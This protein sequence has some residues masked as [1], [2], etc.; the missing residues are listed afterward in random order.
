[1][2]A[3]KGKF[4]L[5]SSACICGFILFVSVIGTARAQTTRQSRLA[6]AKSQWEERLAKAGG[7]HIVADAYPTE[8]A[9]VFLSAYSVTRDPRYAKQAATQLEYCH[10]RETDGILLTFKN[11]TTRD[12]QARH[13]YN[14]YL[15]YRVL[16]DGRYLRWAD[17]SARAM[18]HVIPRAAHTAAGETHTLFFAGFYT[19]EGKPAHANGLVIDVNQNAEVALA[20]SLLYH[21][22]ASAFFLDPAAKEIAYEELLAS[23]SIQEMSSGAIPLTESIPG[24][25]TAYGSYGA[26]SWVWCQ[27]LWNDA[28]FEPHIRAAGKWLGPMMNLSR[29]SQRYYPREGRGPVPN[30]E[31]NYRIPLLWYCDIDARDFIREVATRA[32]DPG[33]AEGTMSAPVYWAYF[34]LMGIPREY[35]VDG[36]RDHGRLPSPAR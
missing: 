20:Y 18:L 23:M 16:A 27:L 14:F 6:V 22:P 12:Y 8:E 11:E 7:K 19:A 28:R 32:R 5:R 29:D 2:H 30:W 26:F 10:T 36:D 33:A 24:A 3:D 4:N 21:D 31:A 34:D 25:D 35:Y 13:I 9:L 15:A 1:M 17:E